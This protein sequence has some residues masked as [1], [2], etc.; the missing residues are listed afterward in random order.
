M[1]LLTL[2]RIRQT[3]GISRT[4]EST[5]FDSFEKEARKTHLKQVIGASLYTDLINNPTD[6][7]YVTLLNGED[8]VKDKKT[9]E[10][11]GVL[12]YLAYAW[13]FINATEG[14]DFQSNIGTVNFNQ[15]N[16]FTQRPGSKSRT[17]SKYQDAMIIYKNEIIDYL[18]E[19]K[20]IYPLWEGND[21]DKRGKYIFIS[22]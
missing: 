22:I 15:Q 13:L 6:A 14:D 12:E 20:S 3:R 17:F 1:T 7:K 19:K 18:R 5:R 16:Q 4:F 9:I 8:Y 10:F 21:K 11:S 2:E